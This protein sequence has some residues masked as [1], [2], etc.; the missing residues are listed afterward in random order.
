MAILKVLQSH[1]LIAGLLAAL[2][3]ALVYNGLI[4][5]PV[6]AGLAKDERNKGLTLVAYRTNGFQPREITLDLWSAE[7]KAPIDLFRALFQASEAL[8]ERKFSQVRLARLG[9]VVFVL[10][11]EDF[12]AL[13]QAYGQGENPI[14]L[15]RTL[16]EKLQ[17]VSG[18][19]AFDTW[20]GGWLGVLG[21]QMEDSNTFAQAWIDGAPTNP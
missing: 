8:G 12:S 9:H 1:R 15:V 21:K 4:A 20:T 16:P 2:I 13:G 11:G 7:E 3:L 14:Y 19:P 17:T 18:A 5:A 10:S 6:A